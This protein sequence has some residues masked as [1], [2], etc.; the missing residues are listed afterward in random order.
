LGTADIHKPVL[1][2]LP[3]LVVHETDSW[4]SQSR[5]A[6]STAPSPI[7]V[8]GSSKLEGPR[9]APCHSSAAGTV[10]ATCFASLDSILMIFQPAT[11]RPTRC[12]NIRGSSVGT[13][14]RWKRVR[15]S[16]PF[17][18]VYS[19]F[20]EDAVLCRPYSARQPGYR[21][22]SWWRG[23][24]EWGQLVVDWGNGMEVGLCTVQWVHAH[25]L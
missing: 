4:G 16:P 14:G 3:Q 1:L 6:R 8:S 20:S 7:D 5:T 19:S 2:P 9:C 11:G 22:P 17:D 24:G 12:S 15:M 18:C 23:T 13:A 25:S 10:A 21:W